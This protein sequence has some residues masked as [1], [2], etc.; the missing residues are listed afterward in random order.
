MITRESMRTK[1]RLMPAR[2]PITFRRQT[3]LGVYTDYA[4][5]DAWWRDLNDTEKA[6]SRGV[7]VESERNWF[8]PQEL[9]ASEPDIGDIVVDSESRSYTILSRGA[10][11]GLGTWKARAVN[12]ILAA[13]L[14]S[15]ITIERPTNV[16]SPEGF[17][18]P[19]YAAIYTDV[20]ARVQ[21]IDGTRAETFGKAGF[22]RRFTVYLGQ[23]VSVTIE[24]R[25]LLD[26]V[27]YQIR[28][29]SN[30]DRIDELMQLSAE[31]IP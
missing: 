31:I 20:P 25:V 1:W 21:E 14:R 2:E 23:R 5:S 26:G 16:I 28:G 17:R 11:G 3:A 7:Y 29:F 15:L 30:P 13:E 10:A 27:V 18:L 19:N 24:D 4:I 8:I 22:P 6:A 9:F 12:L